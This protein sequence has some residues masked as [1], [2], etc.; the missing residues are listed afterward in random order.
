MNLLTFQGWVSEYKFHPKRMWRIDFAQPEKKIAIEV[1]GGAY[2]KGRHTRGSG[3]I[4]DMEKYNALTVLG[5]KLLRY[6]PQQFARCEFVT[7]LEK[8]W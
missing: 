5:W 4:K 3:F 2:S 7:D 6:T 1:E 8:I